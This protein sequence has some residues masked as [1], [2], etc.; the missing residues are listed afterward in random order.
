MKDISISARTV[1]GAI[2][3]VTCYAISFYFLWQSQISISNFYIDPAH[4]RFTKFLY[5]LSKNDN[6]KYFGIILAFLSIHACWFFRYA[7]SHFLLVLYKKIKPNRNN[8]FRKHHHSEDDISKKD[9]KKL[10]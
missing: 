3:L 1:S 5:S 8:E 10:L 4:S 9:T 2:G 6:A 7:A